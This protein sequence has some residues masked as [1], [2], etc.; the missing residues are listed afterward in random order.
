MEA[1]L[2]APSRWLWLV[3]WVLVIPH[4]IVLAFLWIAFFVLSVVAFFAIL[5]TGRY[6]RAIFDFNVGVMRWSWRVSYYANGAFATDRY[7]P[8][9][10]DDVADYPTHLA[11]E[12]PERLSRGLVLIKWWLLALPHYL[13]VALLVGGTFFAFRDDTFR[14]GVSGLIGVL[15]LIA[16]FALL[17]T[18]RYPQ[19]LF[20]LV[21][22]LNRWVLRVGAYSALMTDVYPPFRLDVGGSENGET[23]RVTPPMTPTDA[24]TA[25]TRPSG[26]TG[27][28]IVAL[29]IGALLALASVP[30]IGGGIA[31]TIADQV[32]R[33]ATGFLN[34]LDEPFETSG[35]AIATNGAEI[36]YDDDM[37]VVVFDEIIGDVRVRAEATDP[38]TRTFV[39]VAA[40]SDV[41]GYLGGVSRARVTSFGGDSRARTVSGGAPSTPPAD[42]DFWLDSSIGTG[43]LAVTIPEETGSWAVVVMNADASRGIDV[44]ADIGATLPSLGWLAIAAL[45]IGGVMLTIGA[46]LMVWAVRRAA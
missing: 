16:A 2:D 38:A 3:K 45:A 37:P 26:W 36:V 15:T 40:A 32:A 4:L 20:E 46:A 29:A 23:L 11:I 12:Y 18:G 27:G 33:D 10:L 1:A 13:I 35:Y 5:I 42:Q 6:P 19:S 24:A 22:G 31:G 34:V 39:G 7:P 17:F 28:S 9:T 8:F 43:E 30:A 14:I 44:T 41:E 25:K 21:L